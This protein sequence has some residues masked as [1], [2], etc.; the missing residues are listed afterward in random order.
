MLRKVELRNADNLAKKQ[1]ELQSSGRCRTAVL[2][3]PKPSNRSLFR[4]SRTSTADLRGEGRSTTGLREYTFDNQLASV[5]KSMGYIELKQ[6][7]SCTPDWCG[8]DDQRILKSKMIRPGFCP[9]IEKECPSTGLWVNPRDIGALVVIAFEA[10]KSQIVER[11]RPVHFFR[12]DM[13]DLECRRIK[14][15]RHTTIFAAVGGPVS[16]KAA[17]FRRHAHQTVFRKATRALDC[18]IPRRLLTRSKLSASSDSAEV[19]SPSRAFAA[20]TLIRSCCSFENPNDKSARA[21]SGVRVPARSAIIVSS[22]ASIAV[23]MAKV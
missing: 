17:Q 1:S 22:R 10:G 11:G 19:S 13:V 21:P 14:F 4:D 7:Y 18:R 23:D 15:L 8:T 20:R 5:S 9:W 16:N 2:L 3:F 6:V 12:N